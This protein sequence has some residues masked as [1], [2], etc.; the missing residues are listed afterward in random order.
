[1]KIG[2]WL[3]L[4]VSIFFTSGQV[5]GQQ[6]SRNTDIGLREYFSLWINSIQQLSEQRFQ[7]QEKA[8]LKAEENQRELNV[9]NN[10]F[11]GQLKDQSEKLMPRE[12]AASMFRNL[13]GKVDD[14]KKDISSLR[15]SRSEGGG[16]SNLISEWIPIIVSLV[17][18]YV[19]FNK[20]H[21]I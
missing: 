10:E 5:L 14:V 20:R 1:M 6:T 18:L 19:A 3:I 16:R 4:C 8:I 9:K 21:G 17:A 7:A 13:E 2:V 11:R 15:E 12:E